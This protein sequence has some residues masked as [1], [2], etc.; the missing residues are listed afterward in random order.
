MVVGQ[1]EIAWIMLET[2]LD[3]L[4]DLDFALAGE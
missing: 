1:A 2:V 4:G 3:A